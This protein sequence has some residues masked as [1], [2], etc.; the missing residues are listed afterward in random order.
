VAVVAQILQEATAAAQINKC[1]IQLFIQ[2]TEGPSMCNGS[3]IKFKEKEKRR[4][5]HSVLSIL[6]RNKE[7]VNK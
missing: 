7:Q 2:Q 3:T 6:R 1:K 5:A 4:V